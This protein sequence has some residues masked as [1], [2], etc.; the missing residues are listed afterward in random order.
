MKDHE[1]ILKRIETLCAELKADEDRRARVV[2]MLLRDL[3]L[4]LD[5]LEKQAKRQ[6]RL[7]ALKLKDHA[8]K[9]NEQIVG[10][11]SKKEPDTALAMRLLL[12]KNI[13]ESDIDPENAQAFKARADA[14]KTL[15]AEQTI[16][17]PGKDVTF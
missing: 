8:H 17:A 12:T 2:G 13:L 16:S 11:L 3:S 4:P 5:A 9:L 1:D 7:D 14:C 15:A 10:I 6:K